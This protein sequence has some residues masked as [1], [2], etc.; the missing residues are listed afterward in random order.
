MPRDRVNER[1]EGNEGEYAFGR[2][3]LC[4]GIPILAC[5]AWIADAL[6]IECIHTSKKDL[7][8]FQILLNNE[9]TWIEVKKLKKHFHAWENKRVEPALARLPAFMCRLIYGEWWTADISC[10]Q[11]LPANTTVPNWMNGDVLGYI[12]AR[13][14]PKDAFK[15]GLP[16]KLP[17]VRQYELLARALPSK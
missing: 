16:W 4:D 2:A 12:P 10:L 3:C 5:K 8:D 13:I 15:P 11:G 6:E 17:A 7:L 1:Y 14:W 9:P